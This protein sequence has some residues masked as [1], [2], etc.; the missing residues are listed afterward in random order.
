M[1]QEHH[2]TLGAFPYVVGGLSYIPVAGVLFGAVAVLWGTATRKAGG[3]GL[4]IVGAGGIA[5][6]AVCC[7]SFL[8]FS[9]AQVK[10]AEASLA[11]QTITSLMYAIEFH[12]TQT[13]MYPED[14]H[15][16]SDLLPEYQRAIMFDPMT[17]QTE[18]GVRAFHYE[19]INESHYVLLGV[20]ADDEPYTGDDIVPDVKLQNGS[21]MGLMIEM[22]DVGDRRER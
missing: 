20:G 1:V 10:E 8:Y 9:A 19:L 6:T 15:T 5:F 11:K 2:R 4:A 7:A 14:L 13:G 17:R 12:K 3:K 21:G 18:N 16:L 22:N